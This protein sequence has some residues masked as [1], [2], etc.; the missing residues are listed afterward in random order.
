MGRNGRLRTFFLKVIRKIALFIICGLIYVLIEI[1]FRGYSFVSMFVLAGFCAIFFI[2]TP[3][4][5]YSFDLD[6]RLQI[7]ISTVL[8]TLA[9]GISGLYLNVYKGL[10]IWDYSSL[11]FTFFFGQ[12]N[13]LF[14]AAWTL[15]ITIGIPFCD[16]FN[17]YIGRDE[18]CPYYRING[19]IILKLPERNIK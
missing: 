2:D 1:M 8:C 18:P 13:L 9:E 7:L 16:A 11:P 6:V 5:I 15:I 4:N 10:N 12:C 14:V 17:Y 19:K 3:N